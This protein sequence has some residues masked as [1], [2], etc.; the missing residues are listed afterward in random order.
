MPTMINTRRLSRPRTN[1]PR[2]TA[3]EIFATRELLKEMLIAMSIPMR[4]AIIAEVAADIH[5]T[6]LRF[7]SFLRK[8]LIICSMI[9]INEMSMPT[10]KMSAVIPRIFSVFCC[11]VVTGENKSERLKNGNRLCA[12]LRCNV[13]SISGCHQ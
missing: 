11:C 7:K 6:L 5:N 8:D 12:L 9:V 4:I 10:K 13:L 3:A 2:P 1:K